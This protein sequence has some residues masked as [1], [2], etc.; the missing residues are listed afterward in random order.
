MNWYFISEEPKKP[1]E[2]PQTNETS[3]TGRINII[4]EHD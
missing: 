4:Y 1:K 2:P 3:V